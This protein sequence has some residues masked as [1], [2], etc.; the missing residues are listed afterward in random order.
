MYACGVNN[1]EI[2]DSDFWFDSVMY[3][4][5]GENN[6]LAFSHENNLK[7]STFKLKNPKVCALLLCYF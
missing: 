2:L 5:S 3:S 7:V 4:K 6:T 1:S